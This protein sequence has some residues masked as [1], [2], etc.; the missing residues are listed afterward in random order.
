MHDIDKVSLAL[1]SKRENIEVVTYAMI[2]KREFISSENK[3]GRNVAKK[4]EEYD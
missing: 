2:R 4:E 1:L 3:K